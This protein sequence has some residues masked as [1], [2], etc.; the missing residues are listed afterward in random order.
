[1][2][3]DINKR[4]R[5]AN[6]AWSVHRDTLTNRAKSLEEKVK[7]FNVFITPILTQVIGIRAYSKED[8][9]K[10]ERFQYQKLSYIIGRKDGDIKLS[11][12][13]VYNKCGV[14]RF[15]NIYKKRSSELDINC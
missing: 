5:C 7:L 11:Y 12:H 15:R 2:E 14:I 13:E 6:Y 8:I 10:L 9:N 4:L 1:M 3:A